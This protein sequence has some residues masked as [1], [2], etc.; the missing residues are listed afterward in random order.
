LKKHSK[1]HVSSLYCGWK[2]EPVALS[3]N[4]YHLI[5]PIWFNTT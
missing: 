4:Y 5:E 3:T 1:R 2:M